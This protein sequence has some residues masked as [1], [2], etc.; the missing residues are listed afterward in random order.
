MLQWLDILSLL[1]LAIKKKQCATNPL[2]C[3]D[4]QNPSQDLK[5]QQV[6]SSEIQAASSSPEGDFIWWDTI[7]QPRNG[8]AWVL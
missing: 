5:D 2:F 3:S 1:L 7:P 8:T 4:L 6:R